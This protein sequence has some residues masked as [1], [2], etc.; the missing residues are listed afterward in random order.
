MSNIKIADK[1]FSSIEQ[2]IDGMKAREM[3]FCQSRSNFA[4]EKFVAGMEHTPITKYR[5]LAHNSYFMLQEVR[6][7]LIERERNIRKIKEKEKEII[8]QNDPSYNNNDL[9]IYELSRQLDE[10]EIRIM[11]I[12]KEV[13]YMEKLCEQLEND[14]GKAFT[15]EQLASEEAMYWKKRFSKQILKAMEAGR[16]GAGEGNIESVWQA[17]EYPILEDNGNK[18]PVLDYSNINDVGINAFKG[19][20]GLEEVY[21]KKL[22]NNNG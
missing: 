5:H 15:A 11:G 7:M 2:K 1:R 21:L 20:K 12:L 4:L 8:Q 14:N 9:D 3:E 19:V 16:T 22:E 10:M 6:R 13:D 18:M 17:M